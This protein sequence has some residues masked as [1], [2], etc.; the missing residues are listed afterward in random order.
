MSAYDRDVSSTSY[1]PTRQHNHEK[2]LTKKKLV[3]IT[4]LDKTKFTIKKLFGNGSF[5]MEKRV[6][7]K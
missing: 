7:G 6:V 4:L 1:K 5:Q 2:K 3:G